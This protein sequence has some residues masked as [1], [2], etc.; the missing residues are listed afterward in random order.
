MPTINIEQPRKAS[1]GNWSPFGFGFRPF[2][3]L[4]GFG[5]AVLMVSWLMSWHGGPA[6]PAAHYGQI[7]WH[8]HEMLFGYTAAVIAGF[9]LTAVHNWT[10]QRTLSGWPLGALACLWLAGRV[11]PWFAGIPPLMVA[12]LDMAFLPALT[13]ALF[14]PLWAG[15]NRVN[16]WF[17]A[18]L[19]AM[20]LANALVHAETLNWTTS[21][22]LPGIFMMLDLIV[23]LLI[24]VSGRVMPFFTEKAI[25][26][27][28]PKRYPLVE[29]LSIALPVAM[30]LLHM[31]QLPVEWV[32]SLAL[33]TGLLQGVRWWGWHDRRVWQVP[34]LWV[35]YA[36]YA[37]LALGLVLLGLSEFGLLQHSP[38][39]HALTTGALGVFTLGMMARVAL[40]HTGRTMRSPP[41]MTIAFVIA[42]LA[43]AVRVL[44]PTVMPS[45]YVS[46]TLLAGTLW[47]VAF[48]LFAIVYTPILLKARVDG[49]PDQ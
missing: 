23:L 12:A 17:A 39:T 30:A 38:A 28:T 24:F 19:L 35:L 13:L 29:R 3:L 5:A 37:W 8:A 15:R 7:V 14:K 25:A 2:F 18:L 44:G 9:L 46:W 11:A 48:G 45:W 22:A 16:R 40:G 34:I 27:A 6:A 49:R 36:G 33:G 26:G 4:A 43:A 1:V 21:T 32:G 41:P 10:G 31:L 47:V 42:N 20:A